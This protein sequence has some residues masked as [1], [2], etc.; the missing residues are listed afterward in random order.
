MT[1]IIGWVGLIVGL[2]ALFSMETMTTNDSII[3]VGWLVASAIL[4][5]G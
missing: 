1:R 4:A 3:I 2:I 5:R